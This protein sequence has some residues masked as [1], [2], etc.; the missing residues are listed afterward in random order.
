MGVGLPVK[1]PPP[2]SLR[3]PPPLPP[4]PKRELIRDDRPPPPSPPPVSANVVEGAA[5][6]SL[7]GAMCVRVR[8]NPIGAALAAG[9]WAFDRPSWV[10]DY[11]ILVPLNSYAAWYL[12]QTLAA[13]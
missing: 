11:A 13:L 8:V 10:L 5:R 4:K 6:P 1:P 2:L 9:V 7:M 3:T 12:L